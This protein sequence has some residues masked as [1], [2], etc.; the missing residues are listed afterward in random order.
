MKPSSE[1][2]T[3][4]HYLDWLRVIAIF[5]V[6]IFHTVRPFDFLDWAVNNKELSLAATIFVVFLYP[7]GMPLFF[8]ISGAGTFFALKRRSYKQYIMERVNRLLIPYITGSILLTPIQGYFEVIHKKLYSGTFYEFIIDGTVFQYFIVR[9]RDVG[10]GTRI[11][12]AW[13]FHLWFIGFLF[14]YSL[15]AIPI[16][17]WLKGENGSR[18]TVFIL[19]LVSKRLGV[20]LFIIPLALIQIFLNP[21][22]PSQND[23]AD[24]LYQFLFFVYGYILFSDE[25]FLKAIQKDWLILISLSIVSSV[26]VLSTVASGFTDSISVPRSLTALIIRWGVYSV[27]SWVWIVSLILLGTRYLDYENNL[28]QYCNQAVMSFYFIHHPVIIGIAF[29]VVQWNLNIFIKIF[30]VILGS[31]V[32]TL[33]VYEVIIKRISFLGNLLGVKNVR[34]CNSTRLKI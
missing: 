21:I 33:G 27:N 12:G 34:A 25:R 32:I 11:F 15:M 24:F 7:W 29:Y 10:W 22:F 5:G 16:F 6:F 30:S 4:L 23:W 9:F 26:L 3:R 28:L 17:R 8:L 19:K 31:F 1:R 13:G 14:L 18:F 2:R 20:L